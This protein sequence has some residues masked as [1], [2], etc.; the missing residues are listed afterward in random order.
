MNQREV[1][2]MECTAYISVNSYV[3]SE[4]CYVKKHTNQDVS[5]L[6]I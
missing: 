3:V 5:V 2:G 6:G 1:W 4:K